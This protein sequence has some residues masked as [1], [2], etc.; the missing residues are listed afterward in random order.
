L[1]S[2][3]NSIKKYPVPIKK[4]R[5]FG[6]LKTITRFEILMHSEYLAGSYSG[7]KCL[8]FL[9]SGRTIFHSLAVLQAELIPTAPTIF[10]PLVVSNIVGS[11]PE[12]FVEGVPKLQY[13]FSPP[14]K[15]DSGCLRRRR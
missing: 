1:K 13:S 5:C 9:R 2:Y 6:P 12:G 10:A 15:G 4:F 7:A 3:E 14:E 11:I 8:C